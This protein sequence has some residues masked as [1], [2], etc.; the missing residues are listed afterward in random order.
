MNLL[1][2]IA[3][4]ANE[5][6]LF[7][8]PNII[9]GVSGGPDSVM[10][11]CALSELKKNGAITSNLYA[12]HV[13][14]NLRDEADDD[15]K[16]AVTLCE[17]L[18]IPCKV[19]S[20]DVNRES[21]E[22]GRS[23]EE[24]GRILRYRAFDNYASEVLGENYKAISR[25]AVAHHKDDLAE[26]MMMNLFRG[27][28]LEGLVSPLPVN[29]RII[30]PLLCMTKAEIVEYLNANNIEFAIDKTNYESDC[31]RNIWRNQ[32]LP[33]ISENSNKEATN[34][35]ADTYSLLYEDLDYIETQ[36]DEIYERNVIRESGVVMLESSTI[37][38]LH[39]A[40]SNRIIRKLWFETFGNLTN[41]ENLHVEIARDLFNSKTC[42][43]TTVDLS[44][45]RKAFIANGYVGFCEEHTVV[46]V[47]CVIARKMGVVAY[48]EPMNLA[49]EELTELPQT[50]LHLSTQI[51]ENSGVLEYNDL[52][53]FFSQTSEYQ[54]SIVIGNKALDMK[55]RRAG[56]SG[57]KL[58]KDLL[59]DM[60]IPRS[61]R[62]YVVVAYDRKTR[63]VL[64]IPG[65]GHQM[66]FTNEKSYRRWCE[67]ASHQAADKLIKVTVSY[68]R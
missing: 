45:G 21:N 51:I 10:L 27:A 12:V 58:I 37:D 7:D 48:P 5:Y 11:I 38:G 66:G 68:D 19:Y 42:A 36:V 6:G 41:F 3:D 44:Y 22:I 52:S 29:D 59:S 61:A 63:E 9:V 67:D 24:T 39:R 13:N 20:F 47:M 43:E 25:I 17:S 55:F 32:I 35:L 54:G 4:F 64:W 28:G 1:S 46:K 53:W 26:T 50:E 49:I 62:E 16:L 57:S 18:G 56:A 60:K 40:I 30:R 14:H 31:T 2:R 34:A 23:L 65:V 8:T 33:L 15:M